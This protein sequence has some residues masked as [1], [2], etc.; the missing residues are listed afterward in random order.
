MH[1]AG[2]VRPGSAGRRRP[3]SDFADQFAVNVLAAAELTGAGCRLCGRPAGTVVLV[4]SGSGLNARPPLAGYGVSQVRAARPTP[5]RSARRN[6]RCG[7]APIYPGRTATEMQRAVRTAEAGDYREPAL[8]AAGDGGR[9]ASSSVLT[10]A[11]RREP[12]PT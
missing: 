1:C 6:R 11:G 9:G 5:T 2:I 7:S 4:N 8:P 3:P 12:S 10:P